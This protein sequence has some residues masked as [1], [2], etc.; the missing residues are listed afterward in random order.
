MKKKIAVLTSGWSDDFLLTV[1]EGMKRYTEGKNIDIYLFTSYKFYEHD[2]EPNTTGFA[3]FDV[4]DYKKYDGVVI[5]PNLFNDPQ[6]VEIEHSRIL[7]AEIPAVSI[8][9][10]LDGLD[11]INSENHEAYRQLIDHLI[12]EH[13]ITDFA[14]I[15]GPEGNP[16]SDSNFYAFKESLENHNIKIK[17]E[18]LYLNGDW[19]EAFGYKQANIILDKK[20]PRPQ[21]IVCV[22][23]LAAMGATKAILEHGL[24]VPEDILITGFD[25]I[26]TSKN[27][28]P[29]ITTLNVQPDLMGEM[30]IELLMKKHKKPIT[31]TITASIKY[32]QSCGCV[33]EINKEQI[34]YS[35]NFSHRLDASQRFASQLRHL[36]D[37]FIVNETVEKLNDSLQLYFEDRNTFE[38]QNFAIMMK[39]EVVKSLIDVNSAYGDSTTYGNSMV[40]MVNIENGVGVKCGTISTADVIP[41]N[42]KENVSTVYLVLPIYQYKYLHGYYVSKNFTGLLEDK[43]AY[44]WTR[45]MGTSIEKFRQ[46]VKY[47]LMSEQLREISTH[48]ALSGLMNRMGLDT[49]GKEL[50][51]QN[52]STGKK[53]LV[54]FVDINGM[55]IINDKY[56]HLHGDLAVKTVAESIRAAIPKNFLAVRYGGDEFVILGTRSRS[57][58]TDF[59]EKIEKT[60]AEKTKIMSLPYQLS[61]SIGAKLFEPNEKLFL[62]DAI[63][64]VDELMY[65]KKKLYHKEH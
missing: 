54:I 8:N 27:I 29:S 33:K 47:R 11:F 12:E 36:G 25:D 14:Y 3:I 49:Y 1:V 23:D 26:S 52:N 48:D 15:S 30:A 34:M 32:R 18:N 41:D 31:K 38:G 17:E 56:G 13:H 39:E 10:Q 16:G 22:N 44:N 57:G 53:T 4:I 60:I 42:M 6:R 45:N 28:I 55:K 51:I 5:M 62:L 64:E 24:S 46:T 7:R 58:G 43:S 61:A 35:Q 59:C 65:K 21:A 50:L 63:E 9:Q 37:E 2:G 19:S 20:G 40:V